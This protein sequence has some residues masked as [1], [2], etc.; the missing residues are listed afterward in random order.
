MKP[1]LTTT[2]VFVL[3]LSAASAR[4]QGLG[5]R[6]GA[7][8]NPDQFYVG[9]HYETVEL[10]DRLRFRPNV[11]VG[12]GDN[13]TL[14]AINVEFVYRLPVPVIPMW[15]FYVGGGPA[16]NI[17]RFTNDTDPEGGFNVLA[18]IEHRNGLFTEAKFGALK[19]ARFKL[20]VGYTFHP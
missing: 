19:S 6:A 17:Y 15:Q 9:G 1:T 11:E 10:A 2:I 5:V 8:A 20:C 16:L 4:A 7:S 14:V 18:G 3:I 12:I 13:L